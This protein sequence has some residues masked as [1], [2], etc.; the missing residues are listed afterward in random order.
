MAAGAPDRPRMQIASHPEMGHWRLSLFGLT[1]GLVT[2]IDFSSTLMM[3]VASQH[4]QGGV[5]PRL[6]IT[7]TRCR[8]TR[9][10]RC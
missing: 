3:G 8:P 2:G 10:R 4:I 5:G 7:C 9:P 6:K 1:L